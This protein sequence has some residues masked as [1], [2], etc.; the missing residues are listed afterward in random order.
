[1]YDINQLAIMKAA[2]Y[3]GRDKIRDFY[4]ICFICKN[5]FEELHQDVK[6]VIANAIEYKGIEQY[7]Y[8]VKDQQDDLIDEKK[9]LTDFLLVCDKL[10]IFAYDNKDNN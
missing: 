3:T 7:D 9:L 8:I 6:N 10:G 4:D 5:Y 2:A 1:M